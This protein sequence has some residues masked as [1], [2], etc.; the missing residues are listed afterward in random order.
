MFSRLIGNEEVKSKLRGM[1]SSGR[2]PGALLFVGEEGI[3]KKLFALE[4]AKAS[5]CLTRSGL[6]ACDRC[7]A[8]L[9]I[10]RST[11]PPYSND[12]DNRE[13]II[14]S[15]HLDVAMARAFKQLIRVGPMREIEREANFRPY[16]GVA[17]WFI[18]EDAHR[19][20]DASSN[21]LLKTLEEP[22]PATHLILITSQPAALLPTIRSRCQTIR[23]SPIAAAE[24]EK[25]LIE[26]KGMPAADARLLAK[27]ARGSIGRALAADIEAY[28][29]RR[30]S[31]LAVLKALVQTGDRVRL[32]RSAEELG[33]ARN[34]DEYEQRL[35]ALE[36]LIRDAWA[37]G[38]GRPE[39]SIVNSDLLDELQ[40]IAA[41]LR[42]KQAQSWLSAI[43]ELRAALAVNINRRVATDA[44]FLA[45]AAA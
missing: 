43:E 4:L 13:R 5:N 32:L 18:I 30:E 19:M 23:F 42:S 29:E 8:C 38:L 45:M 16:E 24:I 27:T 33:A 41:P 6:E 26:E 14:W 34:R 21:A 11:F 17:R 9:R 3:G 2:R 36:T 7:S 31:M 20:N 28:R 44:L 35:D 15:E 1:L 37:L 40:R 22:P 12:D 10:S 39:T 25:L